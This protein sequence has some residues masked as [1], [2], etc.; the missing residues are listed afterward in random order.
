MSN[1]TARM[2]RFSLRFADADLEASFAEEQARKSQRLLRLVSLWSGGIVLVVWALAGVIYP[3]IPNAHARIAAPMMVA[4]GTMALGYALFTAPRFLR[5]Q[6]LIIMA[7]V[8]V[9]TA[10]IVGWISVM[11]RASMATV[12]LSL[13][14]LHMFNTY[15]LLRLRF[16]AA[17]VCAWLSTGP[18]SSS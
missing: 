16:P 8:C 9:M 5:S 3:E 2:N 14:T 7:G 11:P 6:Q 13:V 4:L 17:T 10:A 12:G 15:T 18:W 1:D